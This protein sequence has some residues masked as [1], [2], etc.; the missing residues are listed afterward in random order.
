[1]PKLNPAMPLF[2]PILTIAVQSG[3]SPIWTDL[4]S[5]KRTA[6]M[7]FDLPTQTPTSPILAKL[8][9]MSLMDRVLY[10][11]AVMVYKSLN[12]LAPGYIQDMF[13]YVTDVNV[14]STRNANKSKL[15][16]AGGKNLKKYTD[17][18]SY[19]VG[20]IW[21]PFHLMS[22]KPSHLQLLYLVM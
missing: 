2:S 22:E 19:S 16:L 17:N 20:M 13:K 5:Y 4:L 11:K 9:W 1:M 21:I 18:F 10:C 6:Q 3:V 7:I 14:R 12:G 15:Y 8:K